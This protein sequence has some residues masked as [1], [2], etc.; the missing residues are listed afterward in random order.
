MQTFLLDRLHVYMVQN[1]GGPHMWEALG[2]GLL[3]LCLKMALLA[4][5][6]RGPA[7]KFVT[8]LPTC[9]SRMQREKLEGKFQ[10]EVL[11]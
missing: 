8:N 2:P 9:F 4:V 5:N 6:M 1:V 11:L 10:A 7:R 3:G